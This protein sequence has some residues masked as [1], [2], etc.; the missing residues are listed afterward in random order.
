MPAA[1]VAIL[2]SRWA[3]LPETLFLLAVLVGMIW[4]LADRGD[5]VS[6]VTTIFFVLAIG[7]AI[8]RVAIVIWGD[9]SVV[10]IDETGVR[11]RRSPFF[12]RYRFLPWSEIRVVRLEHALTGKNHQTGFS[13]MRPDGARAAFVPV[14]G[15]EPDVETVLE[16]FRPY[17]FV[18]DAR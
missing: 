6:R 8:L 15:L 12:E 1:G 7:V 2:L 18:Q 4:L 5:W 17:G 14:E 11:W 10:L 16:A 9:R 3:R 13:L